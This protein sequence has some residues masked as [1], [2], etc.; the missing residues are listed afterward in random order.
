MVQR[1]LTLIKT[2]FE[3][4]QFPPETGVEIVLAGRSNVGKSTL[5]NQ[6]GGQTGK[7]RTRAG[8][9]VSQKPGCTQSINFYAWESGITLVDFPGFGYAKLPMALRKKIQGLIDSYFAKR[10]NIGL[11][12]H[13]A[14]A[15]LPVQKLDWQMIEWGKHFEYPYL[16]TLNKC[17][18]LSRSQIAVRTNE[19]KQLLR[20]V[21]KNHQIVPISAQTGQGIN[22]LK[23]MIKSAAETFRSTDG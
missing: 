10:Q 16:F 4:K 2:A 22:T 20:T 12:V 21:L 13:L 3:S 7:I 6:L 14:D 18:K 23:Q 11:L 19:M 17:D 1:S 5:I 8:A 15:R 9:R